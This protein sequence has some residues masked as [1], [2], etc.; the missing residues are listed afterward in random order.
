M[1]LAIVSGGFDP[2]H[3]GHLELF[4]KAKSMADSLYVIINSDKFLERKKGKPFMD[5]RERSTIVQALK[6]VN[7]I[8]GSIDVDDTVCKTLK[9][10]HGMYKQRYSEIMFCNGG[11]RTG[12]ANTPEHELC[13]ELGIET[14][15][16]LGEK[17]QSS[18]WLLEK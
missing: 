4:E 13:Q 11:D 15:Y 2:V 14:V 10:V 3:I 8:I 5:F 12:G 17:V 1:K 18:S 16:G 7:M 6:P 9:W